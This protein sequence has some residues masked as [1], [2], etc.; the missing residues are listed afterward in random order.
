MKETANEFVESMF[1]SLSSK[2][3]NSV[4]LDIKKKTALLLAYGDIDGDSKLVTIFG[5]CW[6]NFDLG[7]IVWMLVSVANVKR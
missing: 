4:E 2:Y 1:E 6:Q 3:L 7:D 5:C